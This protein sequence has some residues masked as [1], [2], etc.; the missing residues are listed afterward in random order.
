[1]DYRY[2]KRRNQT[3]RRGEVMAI[4]QDCIDREY[5]Q[6]FCPLYPRTITVNRYKHSQES[7]RKILRKLSKQGYLDFK[8]IVKDTIFY[9]CDNRENFNELRK[10]TNKKTR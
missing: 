4:C 7:M 5:N 1:M 6:C 2:F 10:R 8:G 3:K 9:Q